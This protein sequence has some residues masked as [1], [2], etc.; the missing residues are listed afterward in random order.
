MVTPNE[1]STSSENESSLETTDSLPSGDELIIPANWDEQQSEPVATEEVSVTSDEAISDD[2]SPE[3]DETSEIT[4]ESAVSEVAPDETTI[5][6]ASP[7]ESGRMRTQDE[8]SKRESSIRQ[9]EN[10]RETEMQSLRD[11][12]S[13]LQTTYSDQVLEAEVRGYAQSLEAQL[14]AE[15][16]DEAAANRLATQQA[17]AAKASFQA[18]QR[19]N[20]LQQQLTQANQSAEVTSKNASVNEMMRQYGVPESQRALLQGYSDPALLVEASKVLGEA[21]GLRKQQ[22]AAKQAEVPSGGEANT[23][24]GGVGQGGTITDQQWL[25]TVYASGSSNDHARA[26]KVM[27]SMGVNLG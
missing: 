3:S 25:N 12:V 23:F 9:R 13:Q 24:D 26:N 1:V 14:V 6:E 4:E 19:A 2:V 15:G 7:E 22:I 11:Q 8:W 10:E 16:H 17:N 18:E 20:T 21:E 5:D 27:R